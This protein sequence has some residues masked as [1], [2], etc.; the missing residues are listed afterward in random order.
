MIRELTGPADV[1]RS[2]YPYPTWQV[3]LPFQVPRSLNDRRGHWDE[4]SSAASSGGR[5]PAGR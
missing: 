3:Q 5:P 2:D 1:T 4:A